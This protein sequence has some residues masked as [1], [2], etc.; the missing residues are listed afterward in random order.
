MTNLKLGIKEA[1]IRLILLLY[2]LAS[3][4]VTGFLIRNIYLDVVIVAL[5]ILVLLINSNGAIRICKE[6]Y[7]SAVFLVF[8]IMLHICFHT[9]YLFYAIRFMLILVIGSLFVQ[10]V[11]RNRS[12]IEELEKSIRL[13]VE[14]ALLGYIIFQVFHFMPGVP[15][16]DPMFEGYTNHFFLHYE[17]SEP[18][19]IMFGHTFIRNCGMFWEPGL[20]QIFCNLGLLIYL[21]KKDRKISVIAVYIAC[22]ITTFSTTGIAL[23]VLILL[24][25]KLLYRKSVRNKLVWGMFSIV[26]LAILI[27]ALVIDK[28]E[29]ALASILYRTS[30]ITYSFNILWKNLIIGT[31]LNNN[32]QFES[33][34]DGI[35]GNSNGLMAWLYQTGIAGILFIISALK[36]FWKNSRINGQKDIGIIFIA[37]YI[38]SNC[39]EPIF[40][41]A[42][43]IL[44]LAIILSKNCWINDRKQMQV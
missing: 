13:Y 16:D 33:L 11:F 21:L 26:V 9:E 44:L 34:Y 8:I 14:M 24:Y 38:I 22:V 29:N 19:L 25:M 37:V 12:A 36:G 32:K 23:L 35:R 7:V 31:G 42:F 30:D 4:T 15:V 1:F 28:R 17:L 5:E 43:N 6:I 27:N 3:G 18:R 10:S 40:T 20:L 39:T 41:F 2:I